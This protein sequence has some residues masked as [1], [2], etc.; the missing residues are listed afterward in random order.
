M[1]LPFLLAGGSILGGIFSANAAARGARTQADASRYAADLQRDAHRETMA[2]AEED[3][4][5]AR[6]NAAPFI[7]AGREALPMQIEM[8][9]NPLTYNRLAAE[10][11]QSP[12]YQFRLDEGIK[13]IQRGNTGATLG[14]ATLKAL[15]RYGQG[16]ASQD[17]GSFVN[18]RIAL[19][20]NQYNRLAGIAGTGQATA[21]QAGATMAANTGQVA[22]AGQ[23]FATGAGSAAMTGA[24]AQ[25]QG[26]MGV[27]NA[28]NGTVNALSGIA[29]AA[30]AGLFGSNPWQWGTKNN[31]QRRASF[32]A[33]MVA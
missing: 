22:N 33:Q 28:F 20:G 2:F 12:G 21:A 30:E 24:N 1:A 18:R 26:R 3:R 11:E 32:G 4:R 7:E 27:A 9:N 5:Y 17:F 25:A 14:G 13:A 31:N 10:Y 19:E 6:E 23:A 8:A 15:Q 29:G 16:L